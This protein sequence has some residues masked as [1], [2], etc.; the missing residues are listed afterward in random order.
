MVDG[1]AGGIVGR[2]A[3]VA[4]EGDDAGD[5][6]LH[7]VGGHRLIGVHG[8][9][10]GCTVGIGHT[11]AGPGGELI[12]RVG[13]GG[14]GDHGSLSVG[15]G[16][17]GRRGGTHTGRAHGHG[18]V[19]G[20]L[21]A[22]G[23]DGVGMVHSPGGTRI[24]GRDVLDSRKCRRD[25]YLQVAGAGKYL[26][27]AVLS[28]GSLRVDAAEPSHGHAGRGYFL[29]DHAIAQL[30]DILVVVAME[31]GTDSV[32]NKQLMNRRTVGMLGIDP[33]PGTFRRE[34]PRTVRVIASPLEVL[35]RLRSTTHVAGINSGDGPSYPAAHIVRE[36]ELV[37]GVAVFKGVFQPVVLLF[38]QSPTPLVSCHGVVATFA[39]GGAVRQ[40]HCVLE[41]IQDHEERISPFPGVV[42]LTHLVAID[43]FVDPR[44]GIRVTGVESPRPF[45]DRCGEE[46]LAGL[47]VGNTLAEGVVQVPALFL[48]VVARR[49]EYR[50]RTA[51]LAEYA[52][53]SIQHIL[54]VDQTL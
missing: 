27:R 30:V 7:E 40:I 20:G 22:T 13:S 52:W 45:I 26:E 9:G 10:G 8:H 16:A 53:R 24:A 29:I 37:L 42:V 39:C 50:D 14:D 46:S 23:G 35:G 17:H 36:D 25:L 41:L 4:V 1:D 54:I 48:F 3:G 31:I 15:V 43:G 19:V 28:E 2:V 38:A 6:R 51:D 32:L 11:G 5:R 33:P 47:D 44:Q 49:Q 34:A 21:C 12:S 18:E